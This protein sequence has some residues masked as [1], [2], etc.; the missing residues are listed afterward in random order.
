LQF[1]S[2]ENHVNANQ[3]AKMALKSWADPAP[4][5]ISS[6]QWRRLFATVPDEL[7][8]GY[9]YYR[10]CGPTVW[11]TYLIPPSTFAAYGFRYLQKL[12]FDNSLAALRLWGFTLT[13]SER[14]YRARQS[15]KKVVALMGDL[16]PLAPLVY[17]FHNTVAFYPECHWWTPFLTESNDL[18]DA[19]AKKGIGEDCCFVRAALGAFLKNCYFPAPDLCVASV[20]ATC[21]DMA[22]VIQGAYGLKYPFYWFEIPYREGSPLNPPFLRG[23]K[24][25]AEEFPP[26]SRG[27]RGGSVCEGMRDLL[28]SQFRTLIS[29]LE[30]ITGHAFDEE[31]LRQ[32]IAQINRFRR[33]VEKTRRYA[34]R[35]Y[36]AALPAL[37]MM[38]LEF[39][40]MAFYADPE[41]AL[42]IALHLERTARKRFQNGHTL[43]SRDA[44]RLFWVTP[45][46]DP[47]LLN[48]AEELGGQVVGSE[49]LIHQIRKP[50]RED[51]PPLEALAEGVLDMSLIG[52]SSRRADIVV[53]E[54]KRAKAEGVVISSIFAGS[55]CASENRIIAEEVRRRLGIPV[56]TFNVVGPGKERQQGQILS[57]MQAFMEVLQ[58]RRKK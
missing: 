8:A 29:R 55:H 14:L 46:A 37:E 17:S 47:I 35:S 15:G 50:L 32:T 4:Q 34:Y 42:D 13:E 2:D 18:F 19:A 22:A 20:G 33:S 9:R 7:I 40:G 56:L 53:K 26:L 27:G 52:T 12:R 10:D 31:A 23:E 51:L 30:E 57:R 24:T 21:D 45:P 54:A 48:H 11:N 28:L 58:A 49:Y 44:L 1:L 6:A 16:G 36:G 5:K 25:H 3:S 38:N 41:E 43:T 39:M